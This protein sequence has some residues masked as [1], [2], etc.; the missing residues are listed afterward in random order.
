[1]GLFVIARWRAVRENHDT[2]VRFHSSRSLFSLTQRF[3]AT[4]RILFQLILLGSASCLPALGQTAADTP[5]VPLSSVTLQWDRSPGRDVKGYR[6]HYGTASGKNHFSTDVGKRTT[7]KI[8]N[9][10]VGKKYYFVVTAYNAKGI[11]SSPSNECSVV[12]PPANLKKRGPLRIE[13]SSRNREA[14]KRKTARAW[15][16]HSKN[17]RDFYSIGLQEVKT[18]RGFGC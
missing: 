3:L 4:A 18:G 15:L 10:I 17:R 7:C 11:E 16:C 13:K 2:A 8:S 1:M 12:V 14:E 9:L 5:A 6:V